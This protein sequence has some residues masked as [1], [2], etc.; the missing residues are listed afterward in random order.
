M[1]AIVGSEQRVIE[2]AVGHVLDNRLAG[3]EFLARA[4]RYAAC[5]WTCSCR[6]NKIL[7][8]VCRVAQDLSPA[9]R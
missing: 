6:A 2:P 4:V 3:V 5:S 8:G 7:V 1:P 9:R